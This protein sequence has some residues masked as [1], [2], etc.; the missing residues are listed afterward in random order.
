MSMPEVAGKA[1]ILVDPLDIPSITDAFE[2]LYYGKF[3]LENFKKEAEI[4]KQ[5]F[6]WASYEKI[7]LE[8]VK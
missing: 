6:N 2:R 4:Q 1:G 5:K 3:D 7:L 8:T